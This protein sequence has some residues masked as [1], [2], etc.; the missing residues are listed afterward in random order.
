MQLGR[1]IPER[2]ASYPPDEPFR[3]CSRRFDNHTLA[4]MKGKGS[5]NSTCDFK[6]QVTLVT[7][8]SSGTGLAT[9]GAFAKAAAAL[10]LADIREEALHTAIEGLT[11]SGHQ[12]RESAAKSPK[13]RRSLP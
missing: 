4:T 1:P 9:A 6:G 10:V 2:R 11:S 5:M 12:A 3:R 8:A 7:G 13:G